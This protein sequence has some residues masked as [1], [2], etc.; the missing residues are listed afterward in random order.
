MVRPM[1][2]A[3]RIARYAGL[4][5]GCLLSQAASSADD[6]P[7]RKK[8]LAWEISS[9]QWDLGFREISRS[10]LL[11]SVKRVG[12]VVHEPPAG[13]GD[14]LASRLMI[15][16]AVTSNLKRAGLDVVSG[17][18]VLREFGRLEHAAGG[19]YDPKTGS[20]R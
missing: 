2:N 10:Q 11:G 7:S 15:L 9:K 1:R 3:A 6:A 20:R 5:L 13:M 19:F 17:D 8:F 4:I 12:L 14:R 18:V 16:D